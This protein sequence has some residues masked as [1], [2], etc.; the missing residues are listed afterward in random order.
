MKKIG[1]S[2]KQVYQQQPDRPLPEISIYAAVYNWQTDALTLARALQ[3]FT[4]Q[5]KVS[6]SRYMPEA[7]GGLTDPNSCNCG[8]TSALRLAEEVVGREGK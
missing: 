8:L 5:H 7:V 6:C 3:A 1:G 2:R 4:V